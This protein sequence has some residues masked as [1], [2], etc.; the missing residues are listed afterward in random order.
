[1]DKK[2]NPRVKLDGDTTPAYSLYEIH[3]DFFIGMPLVFGAIV[4]GAKLFDLIF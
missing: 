1:M 4:L 2:Q 3:R